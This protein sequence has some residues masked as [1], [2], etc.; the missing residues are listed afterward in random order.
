MGWSIRRRKGL[1]GGL[2]NLNL[3]KSGL[4]VSVGVKGARVG[5]NAKGQTYSQVS[6]P[7]TGIYN[8]SYH[9]GIAGHTQEPTNAGYCSHCGAQV[10]GAG[11]FCAECGKSVAGAP[12]S[13][14]SFAATP[15]R[16]VSR[17]SI[18]IVLG[19]VFVLMMMAKSCGDTTTP[20]AVSAP[21][22]AT[23]MVSNCGAPDVDDSTANDNPR[24]PIP[25][26]ILE[27]KSLNVRFTFMPSGD[28]SVG[29][30]PPYRWTY[31]AVQDTVTNQ[32]LDVQIASK[33]MPCWFK[34]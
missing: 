5:V 21:D 18:A 3:S 22:D 2:V 29:A 4:G 30:P 6:I 24:P 27:Y 1:L 10:V 34:R 19:I 11:T 25:I 14:S 20:V 31:L 33:R 32:P 16:S 28:T 12:S 23:L 9:A 15:M 17:K 26:R 7:G 13:T 8:R